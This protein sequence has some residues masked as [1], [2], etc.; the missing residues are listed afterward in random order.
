MPLLVKY[1]LGDGLIRGVWSA[2]TVEQLTS[3][4]VPDDPDFGYLALDDQDT[5]ALQE[6]CLIVDE[7]VSAKPEVT[8]TVCTVD[9]TPFVPCTLLVGTTPYSLVPED[10][11]L[12]LTAD[13]PTVFQIQLPYQAAC[14][15]APLTVEA[16]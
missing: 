2:S 11:T 3:Q 14:W 8:L 13:V 10:A 15:G 16:T 1:Q 7:A 5:Q 6:Q 9:V 12:L 4:V